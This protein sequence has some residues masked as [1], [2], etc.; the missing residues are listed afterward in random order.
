MGI[1]KM[2]CVIVS[3]APCRSSEYLKKKIKHGDYVIAADSGY[4]SCRDAGISPNLIVGDFDSSEMPSGDFELITLPSEKDDSDTFYC[5]KVA[6][7]R[8]FNDIEILNALGNR[9]DH[10]YANILCIE[11][12]RERGVKCTLSDEHNKIQ[13]VN[14]SIEINNNEYKYFSVFAFMGK[15]YGVSVEGAY[16]SLHDYDLEPYEQLGLSNCF[17]NNSKVKISVKSGIILLIQSND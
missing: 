7:E 6:T 5:V 17:V 2:K 16:Y 9:A 3:G 14:G 11:Y 4:L 1:E 10:S 15:A 8:G 13:I 12:C